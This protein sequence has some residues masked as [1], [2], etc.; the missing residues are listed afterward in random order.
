MMLTTE[1]VWC[2]VGGVLHELI[3]QA[4]G[5][6]GHGGESSYR[7]WN[8]GLLENGQMKLTAVLHV[9][10]DLSFSITRL[11]GCYARS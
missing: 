5:F 10:E 2:G 7:A 4:Y 9:F 1:R 8:L 11:F 3:L 6:D